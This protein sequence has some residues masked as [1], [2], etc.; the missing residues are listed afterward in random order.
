MAKWAYIE[1]SEIVELHDLLPSAW[2]NFSGFNK[3]DS[4]TLLS[5]GWYSVVKDSPQY[6]PSEFYISGYDYSHIDNSVVETA[7]LSSIEPIFQN[8]VVQLSKPEFLTLLREERNKKLTQTDWTQLIDTQAMFTDEQKTT[9][10]DYRQALRDLPTQYTD[11]EV[12]DIKEVIWPEYP[13]NAT[14]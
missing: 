6:N 1:N 10:L 11:N 4:N 3:L 8:E 13:V 12:V 5:L 9:W 2:R 7:I 14:A